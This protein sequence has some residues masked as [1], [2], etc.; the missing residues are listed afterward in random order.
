MKKPRNQFNNVADFLGEGL[1]SEAPVT[2]VAPHTTASPLQT[3]LRCYTVAELMARR[4]VQWPGAWPRRR[5]LEREKLAVVALWCWCMPPPLP[6]VQ[7]C[8]G[9]MGA[10][11]AGGSLYLVKS[12]LDWIGSDLVWWSGVGGGAGEGLH[13]DCST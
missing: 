1:C 13:Q 10:G 6:V 4:R 3:T 2:L 12:K 7:L 5:L 9:W 8:S 11:Q